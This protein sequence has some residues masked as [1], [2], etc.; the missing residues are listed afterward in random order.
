[1]RINDEFLSEHGMAWDN[2][3]NFLALTR[4]STSSADFIKRIMEIITKEFEGE[5]LFQIKDPRLVLLLPYYIEG[6]NNLGIESIFLRIVRDPAE[7]S[8]SLIA[9]DGFSRIKAL[10]LIKDYQEINSLNSS[11]LQM[12]SIF[13]PEIFDNPWLVAREIADYCKISIAE[14]QRES[15]LSLLDRSLQHF[16][17]DTAALLLK[18]ANEAEAKSQQIA[19]FQQTIEHLNQ[20]I[21]N[22]KQR[23]S[24][25][26]DN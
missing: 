23:I 13:Y 17:N 3:D 21:D 14:I 5:D 25:L 18:Y 9:R 11:N 6:L 19:L 24:Y 8:E 20:A 10:K 1:M 12:K 4:A 16:K 26:E 22:L 2:I 15:I 7:V